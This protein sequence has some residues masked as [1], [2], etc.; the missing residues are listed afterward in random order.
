MPLS[1]S[2][3]AHDVTKNQTKKLSILLSCYFHKVLQHLTPLYKQIFG[4]KGFFFLRERTL[5]FPGFCMMWHLADGQKNSYGLKTL[6]S[7]GDLLSKHSLSQNKYCFNLYEFLK[8]G[9]HTLV[10]KLENRCFCW[11]PAGTV[12]VPE[13][14]SHIVFSYKA[15]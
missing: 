3:F 4:F 15:L 1:N 10:R 11:Y 13:R 8:R 14:D 5:E 7:L 6:P 9:I 12:G 2:W